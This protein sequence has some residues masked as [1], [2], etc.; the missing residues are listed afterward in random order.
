DLCD[1]LAILQR[2]EL[3]VAGDVSDIIERYEVR[4]F[5]YE[6]R[7]LAGGELAREVL[8]R[9]RALIEASGFE[10]GC[11]TITAQLPGGDDRMADLLAALVAAGVRV[12]TCSRV[13]SRLEDVYHRLS[14]DRVN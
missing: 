3:V 14:E 12:V 2:G 13:R 9:H 4:R 6:L 10:D 8:A 11:E 1:Q 5:V 7:L